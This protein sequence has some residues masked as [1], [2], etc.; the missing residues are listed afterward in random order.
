MDIY[1]Q[2]VQSVADRGARGMAELYEK[3]QRGIKVKKIHASM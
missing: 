3:N 1:A 2:N